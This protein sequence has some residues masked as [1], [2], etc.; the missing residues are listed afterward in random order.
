MKKNKLSVLFFVLVLAIAFCSVFSASAAYTTERCT[1]ESVEVATFSELKEALE[2]YKAGANIVL[3]SSISVADDSKD[4]SINLSGT[5]AVTL[6][7]KGYSITVDSKITNILFNITGQSRLYFINSSE[8]RTTP[9]ESKRSVIYFNTV[10]SGAAAVRAD[11]VYCEVSNINVDFSVGYNNSYREAIG[12][13]DTAV[14]YVNKASG[15]N[16]YSGSVRNYMKNG[17]G[18]VV[19][20][21]DNNK[22]KLQ[23]RIGGN[24]EIGAYKYSVSFNPS[25]A[26][27]VKFGSVSFKRIESSKGAFERIN[28]P[29]GSSATLNDLWYT[30]ESG[31]GVTVRNGGLFGVLLSKKV[32]S[33]DKDEDVTATK[34]CEGLSNAKYYTVL[35]CA[36]GH[37]RLCGTCYMA[38]NGIE[39]HTTVKEQGRPANCTLSGKTSGEK[40]TVCAYSSSKVIPKL[41]HDM[42]YTAGVEASCGVDGK[43][44]H[45]YC[46]NCISY[47]ADAAGT[48]KL[49][50]DEIIIE[51]NHVIKHLPEVVPTCTKTGLT[52]GIQCETCGKVT[53]K[54]EIV[55]ATGHKEVSIY[56]PIEATCSREGR[57]AGKKC[58][59]C[60]EVLVPSET[61]PMKP[62]TTKIVEGQPASCTMPGI[63]FGEVCV[64]CSFVVVEQE[65]I[66]AKGHVEMIIEGKKATCVEDGLTDGIA[67][68][69]CGLVIKEQEKIMKGAHVPKLIEGKKATCQ[70]EGLTDGSICEGCGIILEKQEIIPVNDEHK[71]AVIKGIPATCTAEGKTDGVECSLCKKVLS[72]Q[73]SIEKLPHTEKIVKGTPATCEKAGLTDGISCA[74]CSLIIEKQNVIPKIP[75]TEKIVKG[76]EATCQKE[77]KTDGIV[78]GACGEVITKQKTVE[79]LPHTEKIV[80]GTEAT[81]EKEGLSDGSICGTCSEVIKK[82]TVIPKKEH[83]ISRSVI[84]ADFDK[85]GEVTET[86]AVCQKQLSKKE[87]GRIESLKLSVVKYTY[88]GKAKKPSVVAKT[89]TGEILERYKDF[90]VTYAKGRKAIGTYDVKVT[91]IGNYS[92]EKTL[93]FTVRPNKTEKITVTQSETAIKLSWTKVDGATGYRVYLYNEK[94]KKYKTLGTTEKLSC[95]IKKLKAGTVY[96]FAVKAYTKTESGNLWSKYYTEIET[97]TKPTAPAVKVKA[98]SAKASL[99]WKEVNGATG[100][101]V[102]MSEKKDSGYKKMGSTKKLSCTIKNLKKGKTYYFKVK[103]YSKVDGK[104]I[105]SSAGKYVAVKVK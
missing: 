71:E 41:G 95:T 91:F 98:G 23:F 4:C 7:L 79:K 67:C 40:C 73:Q 28:V 68:K 88:N 38:Y 58:S 48:V 10:S 59:V 78:C 70:E 103:A 1:G 75:H 69:N 46:K 50:R 12:S 25:N 36:G 77:G 53:K 6:D 57:T 37:V 18:I 43:K 92:G 56:S 61:I 14:F 21:N 66:P 105:Y 87:I 8:D 17:S 89:S 39:A 64:V 63:T 99:S 30:S 31:S 45:Y 5:G 22:Q 90:N 13:A 72:P 85:S 20:A 44:E 49:E 51:N 9:G 55:P 34:A 60:E 104:N 97:A 3:K 54:Q 86:C 80:K 93:T 29:S 74:V 76:T 15:M 96:K 16:I 83:T 94:T 82:Q 32:T 24:A 33:L 52:L 101:V 35:Q 65:I 62:H 47:Y 2:N 11:N 19:S 84:R 81:C 27:Y 26:R 100:Y 102:Y 42:V